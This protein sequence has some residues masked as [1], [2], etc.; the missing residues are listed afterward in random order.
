MASH[1]ARGRRNASVRGGA[2][3]P[4]AANSHGSGL[5]ELHSG[6]LGVD[7]SG[8]ARPMGRTEV[9]LVQCKLD[10]LRF[11]S[12]LRCLPCAAPSLVLVTA[13]SFGVVF[14]GLAKQNYSSKPSVIAFD[15]GT[16]T[17]RFN[18]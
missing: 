9:R 12:S 18:R 16:S 3:G 2:A 15:N 8:G 1:E 14:A 6:T 4:R 10:W 7:A 17:V 5:E 11:F 13:P